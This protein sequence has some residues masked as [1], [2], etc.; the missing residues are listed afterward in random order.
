M[1][2]PSGTW[3]RRVVERGGMVEKR[4]VEG[5]GIVEK[6]VVEGGGIV[7]ERVVEEES[8]EVVWLVD[9]VVVG[10]LVVL[11][12]SPPLDAS[13]LEES[14][15]YNMRSISTKMHAIRIRYQNK[16]LSK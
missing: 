14:S 9:A 15:D 1:G 2:E 16:Q 3:G 8:V 13:E 6:G 11:S 12:F 5:G 7:E 10:G 4:V